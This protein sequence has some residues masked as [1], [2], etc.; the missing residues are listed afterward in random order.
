MPKRWTTSGIEH[1]PESAGL[2]HWLCA[3]CFSAGL[4]L[5]FSVPDW[6]PVVFVLASVS[7][8]SG[9]FR[10]TDWFVQ[11]P[12]ASLSSQLYFSRTHL[13]LRITVR[14]ISFYTSWMNFWSETL[15]CGSYVSDLCFPLKFEKNKWLEDHL[16]LALWSQPSSPKL[17][18]EHP[19][20]N[21]KAASDLS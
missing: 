5:C 19:Q 7:V 15:T 9:C 4:Q 3:V 2:M 1:F 21:V 14:I 20:P 16:L 8:W 6:S 12:N 18:P 17:T 11:R 10:N 13:L